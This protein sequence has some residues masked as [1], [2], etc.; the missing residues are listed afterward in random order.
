MFLTTERERTAYFAWMHGRRWAAS[1]GLHRCGRIAAWT[2]RPASWPPWVGRSTVGLNKVGIGPNTA[3][4]RDKLSKSH[5]EEQGLC[6]GEAQSTSQRHSALQVQVFNGGKRGGG[7]KRKRG[8]WVS[9]SCFAVT[10][11]ETGSTKPFTFGP[12]RHPTLKTWNS[13]VK[14]TCSLVLPSPLWHSL[15]IA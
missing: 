3:T 6:L 13:D 5:R 7:S 8:R 9:P 2:R 15:W 4:H 10:W 12:N 1:G 11:L 14:L